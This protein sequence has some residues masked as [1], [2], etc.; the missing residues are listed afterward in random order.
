MSD[1]AV[2]AAAEYQDELQNMRVA[3]DGVK[4]NMMSKFLPGMSQVMKGLSMVF[5]GQGGIEEIK[6]GLGEITA[7]IVS[8]SPEFFEIASAIVTS[9]LEGFGAMLPAASGAISRPIRPMSATACTFRM[10]TSST[11]C[12]T[13]RRT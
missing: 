13:A 7:N 1:D 11:P 5:S 9:I 4:N 12:S 8:L 2:K 3:L 6:A 10:V